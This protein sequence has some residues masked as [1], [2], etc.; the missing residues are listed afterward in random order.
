MSTNEK[1]IAPAKIEKTQSERF[2]SAVIKEFSSNSGGVKV[3][4]FQEKLCNNYFIKLNQQL[5]LSEIKRQAKPEKDRDPVPVTWDNLD[6]NRLATDVMSFCKVGLDPTLP[7]QLNLTPFKNK[8]TGKY[9]IV[10]LIGY[11]GCELKAKKYGIDVPSDVIVEVVYS[12][13]KFKQIKRDHRNSIEGYEFEVV[14]D[15]DRGEIIGGFYYHKFFDTPEKNRIR[16]FNMKDILKRKPKYASTEFWGGEK[17]VWENG[18][19][20]NKTEVVEGWLDEMVYK[21]LYRAAYD[22]ITI[23]SQKIDDALVNVLERDKE[24]MYGNHTDQEQKPE[25]HQAQ[26]SEKRIGFEK[27]IEVKEN[28]D[29]EPAKVEETQRQEA[30]PNQKTEATAPF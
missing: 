12:T 8:H 14:N 20:T 29:L 26:P 25:Q 19:M 15:F 1:G 13:D 18:R 23:D 6:L 24:A 28:K 4:E 30:N 5:Q 2:T 11:K 9:D 3:T 22:A 16:V 7:N 21:T 17:A 10:F 27:P